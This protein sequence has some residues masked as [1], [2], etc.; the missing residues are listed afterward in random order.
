[1]MNM[2]MNSNIKSH[3]LSSFKKIKVLQKCYI[4]FSNKKFFSN[5]ILIKLLIAD[6]VKMRYVHERQDLAAIINMTAAIMYIK[7]I[8]AES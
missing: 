8:L 2:M 4:Y 1:M 7:D 6:K 5:S 3:H